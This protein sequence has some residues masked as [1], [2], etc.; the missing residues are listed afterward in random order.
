MKTTYGREKWFLEYARQSKET[1][2]TMPEMR[3]KSCVDV[4]ESN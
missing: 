3:E 1:H 2:S 4:I